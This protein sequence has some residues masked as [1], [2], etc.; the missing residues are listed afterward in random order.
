VELPVQAPGEG[1]AKG[2][3]GGREGGKGGFAGNQLLAM[4]VDLDACDRV[5]EGRPSYDRPLSFVA[6]LQ[7]LCVQHSLSEHIPWYAAAAAAAVVV[8]CIQRDAF[9]CVAPLA[10][11]NKRTAAVVLPLLLL[12]CCRAHPWGLG[13]WCLYC[14]PGPF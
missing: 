1:V 9:M 8:T 5:A 6:A 4:D 12:Y 14:H 11:L 13:H 2:Y 7:L 10:V 3:G